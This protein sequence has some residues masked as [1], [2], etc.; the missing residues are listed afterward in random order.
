MRAKKSDIPVMFESGK[1]YARYTEWAGMDVGW[2]GWQ[3]GRDS[4]SLFKGLPDDR[5]QVPH[6]GYMIEGRM[7][8]KY[9]D[10][11]EVINAGEVFYLPPGHIAVMEEDSEFVDFQPKG[12][13]KKTFEVVSRNLEAMRKKG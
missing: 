11:D 6:W 7:R 5:C 10:H 13:V 2:E 12:E 9:R 3:G 8:I 1:S 4:T